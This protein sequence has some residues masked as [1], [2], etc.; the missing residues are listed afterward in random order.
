MLMSIHRSF[1]SGNRLEKHR[2]VL[3]RIER[4]A[5]LETVH[6]WEASAD[7]VFKLPKIRNIKIR[8]KKKSADEAEDDAVEAVEGEAAAEQI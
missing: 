2:N 1:R 4:I 5:K 3:S 6:K 8:G 7:S